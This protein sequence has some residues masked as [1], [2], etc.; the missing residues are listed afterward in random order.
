M[1]PSPRCAFARARR[2][3]PKKPRTRQRKN[4]STRASVDRATPSCGSPAPTLIKP[5][6][7]AV[8]IGLEGEDYVEIVK[9]VKPGEKVL[10]RSKSLKEDKGDNGSDG[11]SDTD[12]N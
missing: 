9:G 7:R 1:F 2:I 12:G 8:V 6:R 11:Q 3:A 4:R 5:I 10:V